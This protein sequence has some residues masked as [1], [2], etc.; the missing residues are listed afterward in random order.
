MLAIIWFGGGVVVG[1]LLV[2]AFQS[3]SV[4]VDVKI[5]EDLMIK[6]NTI[7]PA[8]V[9]ARSLAVYDCLVNEEFHGCRAVLVA[10]DGS[11]RVLILKDY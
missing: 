9:V 3:H 6:T 10:E 2:W 7:S 1:M 5:V 8:T 4:K 11:E